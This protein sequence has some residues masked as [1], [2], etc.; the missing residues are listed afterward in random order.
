MIRVD[1]GD[2][3]FIGSQAEKRCFDAFLDEVYGSDL[4]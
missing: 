2:W 4:E 1:D 3:S